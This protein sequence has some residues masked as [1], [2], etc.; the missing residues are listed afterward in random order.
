V[1]LEE[2]FNAA[3]KGRITATRLLKKLRPLLGSVTLNRFQE[4][5]LGF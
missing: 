5:P 2:S 4:D 3:A 1:G